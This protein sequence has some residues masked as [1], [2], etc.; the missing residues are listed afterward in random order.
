[1]SSKKRLAL[2]LWGNNLTHNFVVMRLIIF[3]I[4]I[5]NFDN[6]RFIVIPPAEAF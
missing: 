1:M 2:F 4:A 3:Y 5:I 6:M